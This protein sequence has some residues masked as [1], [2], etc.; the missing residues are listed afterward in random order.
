MKKGVFWQNELKQAFDTGFLNHRLLY[1]LEL[2]YQNKKDEGLTLRNAAIYN[3]LDPQLIDCPSIPSTSASDPDDTDISIAGLYLQDLITISPQWK[4]MVGVG[5]TE[6]RAWG[7]VQADTHAGTRLFCKATNELC[8]YISQSMIRGK[9]VKPTTNLRN[10]LQIG[11]QQEAHATLTDRVTAVEEG[12]VWI[13]RRERGRLC[14]AL[15]VPGGVSSDLLLPIGLP[16]P[17]SRG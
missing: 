10:Q 4:L 3:I 6:L 11:G 5:V 13:I 17:S 12:A 9:Q 1:G 14:G 8:S 16:V 15:L 2:G 7:C